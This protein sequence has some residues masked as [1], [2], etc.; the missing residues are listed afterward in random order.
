MTSPSQP[1]SADGRALP[2][3]AIV[4]GA[5]SGIGRDLAELLARDHHDLIL[6]ARSTEAL[7]SLANELSTRHGVA[8]EPFVADLSRRDECHRLAEHLTSV[9]ERIAVLINN[10]GFGDHGFFHETALERGLQMIDVNVAA[11]THLTRVVLPGMVRR[12]HGRIVQV[13]SVAAFQPGP[14]MSVYY[15]SKAFVL[16]FSEALANETEGTGVTVTALCPGPTATGFQRAAGIGKSAP[17]SGAPAMSSAE[18]ARLGYAA[19]MRGDRVSI[20]GGWNKMI[21]LLNRLLPRR[22]M[23]RLVRRTQERRLAATRAERAGSA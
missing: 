13:G 8:C 21:V 12:R 22:T 11:L 4:T 16:S 17:T 20:P 7:T 15:A 2:P 19:I 5:S 6:V 1:T 14:L 18:V 9:D 10:A 23:T 3:I